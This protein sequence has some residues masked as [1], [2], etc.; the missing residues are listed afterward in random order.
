MPPGLAGDANFVDIETSELFWLSGPTR[1]R[2]DLRCG[3]GR[4]QI[5]DDVRDVYLA[6]LDGAALPGRERG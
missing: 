1:D 6:F 2:S 3:P 5:G 4:P